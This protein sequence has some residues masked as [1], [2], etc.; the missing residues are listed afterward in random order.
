[1]IQR[2]RRRKEASAWLHELDDIIRGVCGGF[3]FG[4]PL[5]YTMEIWWIGAAADPLQ[6]MG[7]LMASLIGVFLLIR[8]VGFRKG[9]NL[10]FLD[11]LMESV[12]AVAIGLICAFL[13]L[14]LLREITP[15]THFTGALGMLIFEGMPFSFGVALS[16]SFLSGDRTQS[17][18]DDEPKKQQNSKNSTSLNST[19]ADLNATLLGAV[20]FAFN[21]APTDEVPMLVAATSSLWL[22]AIIGASLLISYGIVFE[23]GFTSEAKR[24]QQKGIF[25]RPISET[26][27]A[28]LISLV[29]S[30]LLLLFFHQL[31]FEDPWTMW[32]SYTLI[33]GLPASIGGAA[34]RLIV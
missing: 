19:I 5:L 9:S 27:A 7:S 3:L 26:I 16:K 24:L 32:L 20:M 10:T 18:T 21:I 15:E 22:L 6:R 8:T 31:S 12:E 1:M 17:P 33:L 2:R 23:A 4:T 14:V 11:V 25:Q 30:A 13:M 28:Y 34:G 29:A